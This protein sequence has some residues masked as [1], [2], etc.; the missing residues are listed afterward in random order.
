VQQNENSKSA[1]VKP[2]QRPNYDGHVRDRFREKENYSSENDNS[3]HKMPLHKNVVQKS[4]DIEV[5]AD[6][7]PLS[8]SLE[9]MESSGDEKE[10]IEV[11]R[12][13]AI[14]SDDLNT[15][16]TAVK[17]RILSKYAKSGKNRK[18]I[19]PSIRYFTPQAPERLTNDIHDGELELSST[20][21]QQL[22]KVQS[23]PL[24]K[25]DQ[26]M[27]TTPVRTNESNRRNNPSSKI[28]AHDA[29]PKILDR[30]AS[31]RV[32]DPLKNLPS[33]TQGSRDQPAPSRYR[34]RPDLMVKQEPSN[35]AL[36]VNQHLQSASPGSKSSQPYR[37]RGV[38]SSPRALDTA[39][40]NSF[41]PDNQT[42]KA[43]GKNRYSYSTKKKNTPSFVDDPNYYSMEHRLMQIKDPIQRAGVRLLWA[44][45]IP[46]QTQARRYL[47]RQ[48]AIKKMCAVLTVQS[49][50]RRWLAERD[51]EIALWSAIQIQAA[52]RGWFARDS[53]EDN[54]YCATQIQR[55][56]RGYLATM[57]VFED[58]YSI[59]IVQ[60]VVRMHFAI[61]KAVDRLSSIIVIQA[62]YRGVQ[63]RCQCREREYSA[64]AIQSNW[65]RYMSQISYQFDIIDII[66][67][68]SIVRRRKA[69]LMRKG[70]CAT[71]IQAAWRSYDCSMAYVHTLA[72]VITVQSVV[73][74]W[75][76]LRKLAAIR[77][78]CAMRVF[79]ARKHFAKDKALY[80]LVTRHASATKIQSVWRSYCAQVQMLVSIVNIIVIQSLW[81]KRKIYSKYGPY[82]KR[83]R[84]ARERKKARAA[85]KIQA[86][87]RGFVA[88]T[89]FIIFKYETQASITIQKYWRRYFQATNYSLIYLDIVK[90]QAVVRGHQ[91]RS[92]QNFRSDCATI[93]QAASRRFLVRREC[94]NECMIS[95]LISAAA[96]SLRM[97]NSVTKIQRWWYQ[98]ML[99]RRQKQAALIIERFFI[100]VKKE[101][102]KEV[103]ALKKK[104]KERRLRRKMRQS[105]EWILER[106]WLNTVEETSV[107]PEVASLSY[108]NDYTNFDPG[109][110]QRVYTKHDRYSTEPEPSINAVIE[111][112]AQSEVSGLTDLSFGNRHLMGHQ[113]R[114]IRKT[115]REIEEESSLDEAFLDTESKHT[116]EKLGG[117][118]G[119]SRR[120]GRQ[121]HSSKHSSRI[122]TAQYGRYPSRR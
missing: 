103:K 2:D 17:S 122:R 23:K 68:Q 29:E 8:M 57:H 46:I 65:R 74:R 82:L 21:T 117:Y 72:D 56:V 58:L 48:L 53:L 113:A 33:G 13:K 119:H 78:Q 75:L 115:K 59:T 67:V 34:R 19:R 121:N 7:P 38:R 108:H 45:A 9:A 41:S 90:I 79:L 5:D 51:L 60:S 49:F 111:E 22:P 40:S 83:I 77:I 70:L 25:Y 3:V 64:I 15:N 69:I 87:W 16:T 30:A 14:D 12:V 18:Q 91:E 43:S 95:I 32:T 104:K 106:A 114:K 31:Q 24:S 6:D 27:D 47:A 100:F 107:V 71:K 63:C 116:G 93:I 54:H 109:I 1:L 85:T 99:T 36:I 96:T 94:H 112:D 39:A 66:I 42:T 105:D 88:C 55:V 37:R 44:A 4:V 89:T 50:I 11:D 61:N 92:W 84:L 118:E 35:S 26:N 73:R 76:T 98:E 80:I 52:W 20:V 62:W 86:I 101:V 28:Q 97:R 10:D 81:R 110:G 102:E 120:H